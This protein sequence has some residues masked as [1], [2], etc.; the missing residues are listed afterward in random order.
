VGVW[1]TGARRGEA[2]FGV[3][4]LLLRGL[5]VLLVAVWACM[6]LTALLGLGSGTTRGDVRGC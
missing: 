5:L 6:V 2:F 4:L 3:E 1:A